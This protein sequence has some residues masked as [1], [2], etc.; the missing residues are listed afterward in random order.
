MKLTSEEFNAIFTFYDKVRGRTA[1]D[2][3][4]EGPIGRGAPGQMAQPC[5]SESGGAQ[6]CALGARS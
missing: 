5:P 4:A 6:Y 2:G 1:C 3:K